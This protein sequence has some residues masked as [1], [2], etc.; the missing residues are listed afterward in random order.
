MSVE[1]VNLTI[2]EVLTA[3][4]EFEQRTILHK[5]TINRAEIE[6]IVRQKNTLMSRT[7]T[8]SRNAG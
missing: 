2:A 5:Y 8:K 4:Y 7:S 6:A 1:D 3:G